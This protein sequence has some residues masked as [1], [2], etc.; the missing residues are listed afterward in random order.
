MKKQDLLKI[1]AD[2]FVPLGFKKKGD[3]FVKNDKSI[4][5]MIH[6][7]KSQFSERVYLNYGYI[8]NSLP[9]DGLK[10]HVFNRLSSLDALENEKIMRILD[11]ENGLNDAE[12][13]FE[14]RNVICDNLVPKIQSIN[15]E[16][17]IF[18]DLKKRFTLNDIPLIV[19]EHF[20]L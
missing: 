13:E 17:D 14:L 8:I 2:I 16:E 7:Q 10:M 15:S 5:I 18:N 11:L 19:K 20:G 1:L 3:Y 4:N 9:L 12:R 6:L